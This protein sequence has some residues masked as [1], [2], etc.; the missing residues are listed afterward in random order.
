[1][2]MRKTIGAALAVGAMALPA[3]AG[4]AVADPSTVPGPTDPGTIASDYHN[5]ISDLVAQFRTG[6]LDQQQ[7][8]DQIAAANDQLR[9]AMLA[10]APVVPGS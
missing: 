3:P 1:M 10:N 8:Q 2:R 9:D 5:R 6:S 7:L 4:I